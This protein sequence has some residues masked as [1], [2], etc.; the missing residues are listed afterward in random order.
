[1]YSQLPD[2]DDFQG[3]DL[4]IDTILSQIDQKIYS[5]FHQP[6]WRISKRHLF[7]AEMPKNFLEIS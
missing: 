4:G 3:Y 6:S 7:M 5:N 2:Y 1:M